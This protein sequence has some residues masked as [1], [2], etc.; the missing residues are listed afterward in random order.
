MKKYLVPVLLLLLIGGVLL[1][2]YFS[3][4]YNA[5]W[6]IKKDKLHIIPKEPSD[7]NDLAS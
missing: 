6:E 2:N 4:R 5:D 1:Y 7:S 3:N